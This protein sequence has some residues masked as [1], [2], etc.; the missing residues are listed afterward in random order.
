MKSTTK[1]L[2][3]L[4]VVGLFILVGQIYTNVLPYKFSAQTPLPVDDLSGNY[5][6]VNQTGVWHGKEVFSTDFHTRD[7][8]KVALLAQ[9]VL[10]KSDSKKRIEVDLTT[11]R[12]YTFEGDTKTGEYLVSTGLWDWTPT[13]EFRIWTKLES[14]LMTGGNKALGTYYYLP[15]VPYTMYFSNDEVPQHLGY[16]IHGTYWHNDFGTPRSH[17]CINMRTED[18]KKLFYWADEDTK[19]EIYGDSP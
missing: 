4:L 10:G 17:G 19:I 11:Q 14:T 15:N 6:Y 13:G 2:P 16:G 12:L 1:T 8:E 9:N 3:I 18:A 5:D 7:P